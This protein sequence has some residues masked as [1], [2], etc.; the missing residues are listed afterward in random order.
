MAR[1]LKN[2]F[3]IF[4]HQHRDRSYVLCGE[5]LFVCARCTGVQFGFLVSFALL[6]ALYGV[7]G[8]S[9]NFFLAALLIVPLGID[10]LTQLFGL[11]QSTNALRFVTGYLAG[12]GA[13]MIIYGSVS[14]LSFSSHV[15]AILPTFESCITLL[16][17]V[18]FLALLEKYHGEESQPL[19][20]FLNSL[21][22]VSF[23]VMFAGII[24]MAVSV[25]RGVVALA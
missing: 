12:F 18:L 17:L 21:I 16:L 11:R 24:A 13:A 9:A 6:F 8:A 5:G 25:I 19:K 15:S 22:V 23:P 7:F 4:C 3:A 2:L 20:L 1:R 10:G 14:A